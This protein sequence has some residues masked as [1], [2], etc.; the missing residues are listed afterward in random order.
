MLSIK[1]IHW[2][3]ET[4]LQGLG[5]YVYGDVEPEM[6]DNAI[7]A[8]LSEILIYVSDTKNK[9]RLNSAEK[10]IYNSAV[11]THLEIP[12]KENDEYVSELHSENANVI[13]VKVKE[14][15][16]SCKRK[17]NKI[18]K[19]KIYF[20]ETA[21]KYNDTWYDKC[22]IILGTDVS[23]YYGEVSEIKSSFKP[24]IDLDFHD[25]K[26]YNNFFNTPVWSLDGSKIYVKSKKPISQ[27]EYVYIKTIDTMKVDYCLNKT[28]M[29][30]EDVQRYII[31]KV[32]L[33]LAVRTEHNQQKIVNLKSETL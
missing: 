32:V 16:K 6:I 18:E 4:D 14:Y 20:A 33:R 31:D 9:H 25:Y 17:S 10:I 30:S 19:G 7:N 29:L 28:L 5:S 24:A 8:I 21:V 22:S 27:I 1:E 11:V 23:D 13:S 3:I 15:D 26:T 2:S 12:K